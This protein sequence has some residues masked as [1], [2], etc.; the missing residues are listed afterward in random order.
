ME[1]TAYVAIFGQLGHQQGNITVFHA[2]AAIKT[3][4]LKTPSNKV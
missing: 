1:N 4:S 3:S 2:V